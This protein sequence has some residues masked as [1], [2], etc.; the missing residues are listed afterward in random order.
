[1]NIIRAPRATGQLLNLLVL[2][3]CG[4]AACSQHSAGYGGD[5]RGTLRRCLAGEPASLDP[6]KAN[7]TFSFEVIR[8][9]YEGLV[10]EAP[11][12]RIVPGVATSWT[13]SKDGK[14][15][16][17]KFRSNAQWSNGQPVVP[18]DF[19]QAWRRIVDP[20]TGSPVAD[21]LRPVSEASEIIAGHLPPSEL[22]VVANGKDELIV[23]LARPSPYF[24][25]L[26]T[27]TALLPIF[28]P[29]AAS[30]HDPRTW[31]SDGPYILSQ[32]VPGEKLVLRRNP[33]FWDEASTH[34]NEVEYLITTDENAELRDFLAGDVDITDTVPAPA[35]SWL[36]RA[37]PTELRINPFLGV[38]YYAIN[39]HDANLR[40]GVALR[41]ALAMAINRPMLV[42]HIL[43]ANQEAAFGF[44]P[45]GTMNYTSQSWSWRNEASQL[46]IA[47]AQ[48]LYKIAG[49]SPR[50]PLH[51]RLLIN[52]NDTIRDAAIATAEMW[53]STLGVQTSIVE[54]E[55]R[56]F[57]Q[58]RRD[59]SQWDVA[60]LGWTA[61]YDD[62][63]DFLDI[64]RSNSANNDARYENPKFDHLMD[65]ASSTA[66]P[67]QRR[68][69]LEDAERTMLADY[70]VIPIYF[71]VSKRLV[72]PY[73]LGANPTVLN[74]VYSRYISFAPRTNEN[75]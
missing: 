52:S 31:V 56:V 39:M 73:I 62:A 38:A 71:Y 55:Y 34:I 69:L 70:P 27:H 43:K 59:P 20:H 7:D 2:L 48:R 4:L 74:R 15:Y 1:M 58:T 32:W 13:V 57:L 50:H 75:R 16:T 49:Y 19:V 26:L 21:A 10:D 9:T 45:I 61:D 37:R 12:G 22:G 67:L 6:G 5:H 51:L 46:Q 3:C 72:K 35:L 47:E 44:V 60:R 53:K 68:K 28:S 64:F 42:S 29:G 40:G 14:I 17:F 23:R 18:N 65:L 36:H 11:D 66:D 63:S 24:L 25:Q 54:Q 33:R 8:D 41:Q 30:T